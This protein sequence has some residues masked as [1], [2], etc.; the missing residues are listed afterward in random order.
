MQHSADLICRELTSTRNTTQVLANILDLSNSIFAASCEAVASESI[1]RPS[2]QASEWQRR[3]EL[4]GSIILYVTSDDGSACSAHIIGFLFVHLKSHPESGSLS[5]LPHIWLAG[6][7]PLSRGSG[8]FPLMLKHASNHAR[9]ALGADAMT[10]CTYPRR[11]ARMY[12][13]LKRTGWKDVAWLDQTK[14][15][16]EGG[17][18]KEKVLM[19]L[20]IE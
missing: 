18:V 12:E 15:A 17:E 1:A 11:F 13:I 10:V 6:V 4:P 2:T 9:T 14:D 3:L 16:S 19:R 7:D 8:V 20:D 5:P